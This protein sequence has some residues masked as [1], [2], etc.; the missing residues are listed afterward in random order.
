MKLGDGSVNLI[1]HLQNENILYIL[2]GILHVLKRFVDFMDRFISPGA[3]QKL[4]VLVIVTCEMRG[5]E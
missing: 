4:H 1:L 2:A 5:V 3:G